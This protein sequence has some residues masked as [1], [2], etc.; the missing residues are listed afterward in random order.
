MARKTP[1]VPAKYQAS[2]R[3]NDVNADSIPL[4]IQEESAI[5]S[6]EALAIL[7]RPESLSLTPAPENMSTPATREAA[8]SETNE[9]VSGTTKADPADVALEAIID[10]LPVVEAFNTTAGVKNIGTI[11]GRLIGS[12]TG[13]SSHWI[14]KRVADIALNWPASDQLKLPSRVG[15]K[16]LSRASVLESGVIEE[17]TIATYIPV[18]RLDGVDCGGQAAIVVA[19]ANRKSKAR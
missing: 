5:T 8:G 4:P 10:N 3:S 15:A 11:V 9:K 1:S 12:T 7:S 19:D 17:N 13:S 6:D 16:L 14:G 18:E 2:Q